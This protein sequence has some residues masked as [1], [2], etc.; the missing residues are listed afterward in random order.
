MTRGDWRA[1]PEQLRADNR[2]DEFTPF[3]WFMARIRARKRYG[4]SDIDVGYLKWLWEQ[5]RGL[6]PL[7][8]WKLELPTSTTGFLQTQGNPANASLDRI[9][10]K[11]G[12]VKGNVRYIAHMANQAKQSWSDKEVV[13][14]CMAVVQKSKM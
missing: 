1:R 8:D 12:Y 4:A 3:R 14:F 6:C 5:Q 10:S 9:D 11:I 2:R 7:T 13:N